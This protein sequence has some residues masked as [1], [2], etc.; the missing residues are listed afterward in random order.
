MSVARDELFR[1]GRMIQWG[2]QPKVRPVQSNEYRDLVRDY[3][4][5]TEFRDVVEEIADGLGLYVLDVSEHGIVLTPQDESV[6]MMR[7]SHFRSSNSRASDRL[8]DGLVQVAI[9]SVVFPRPRDLEDDIERPRPPLTLDEVD[10]QL[11]TLARLFAEQAKT[12]PDPRAS[13]DNAGLYEAWRVFVR[14]FPLGAK[15][16]GRRSTAR[17]VEFGLERLREMGCFVETT[18]SGK[19]AWQPT[20]RYNVLV[21]EMAASRLYEEVQKV[22]EQDHEKR[23]DF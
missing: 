1:A 9:A 2:L 6:F 13:D 21:Q 19:R 22:L 23:E 7:A 20:R 8:I 15:T 17:V 12:G 11:R 16:E 10:E 18:L 3:I 14:R 5:R 4:N